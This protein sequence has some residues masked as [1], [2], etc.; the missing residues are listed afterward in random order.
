MYIMVTD[1]LK[2]QAVRNYPPKTKFTSL[3]GADDVVSDKDRFRFDKYGDIYVIGKG[4][5]RF[6]Y[7]GNSKT[8][9]NI[10]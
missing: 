10:L 4:G 5:E 6:I 1:E 8:W 3:F 7:D 9:A 2:K